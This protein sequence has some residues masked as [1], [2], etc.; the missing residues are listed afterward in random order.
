MKLSNW[1]ILE[2]WS[3]EVLFLKSL[4]DYE[5]LN[6]KKTELS[7][8]LHNRIF[9]LDFDLP[10]RTSPR[11]CFRVSPG[12]W[13]WNFSKCHLKKKYDCF[14]QSGYLTFFAIGVIGHTAFT[15]KFQF[16]SKNRT[17]VS[18]QK[19]TEWLCSNNCF[20]GKILPE[21][22]YVFDLVLPK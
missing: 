11:W 1:D 17:R 6:P 3:Q 14:E 12:G 7:N 19:S 4:L 16:S 9:N 5:N 22:L 13:F 15:F 21:Y 20:F 10:C 18:V 8:K 2:Y